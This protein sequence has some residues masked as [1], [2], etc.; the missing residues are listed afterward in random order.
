M[1]VP[2]YSKYDDE[3]LSDY[4][5]TENIDTGPPFQDIPVTETES[6]NEPPGPP[7]VIVYRKEWGALEEL[8]E[9]RTFTF[10]VENVIYSYTETDVCNTRAECIQAMKDMQKK[11]MEQGYPDIKFN[12]VLGGDGKVYEG[13]G[14]YVRAPLNEQYPSLEGQH[15]EFAHTGRRHDFPDREKVK[16]INRLYDYGIET[17]HIASDSRVCI[18][19]MWPTS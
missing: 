3:Y 15:I 8:R 6:E 14:W 17:K 19:Y 7:P 18:D 9:Q 2:D 1:Y 11:H 13:T 10:P 16:L 12:F 5:E 4:K